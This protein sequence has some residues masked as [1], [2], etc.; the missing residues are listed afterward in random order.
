MQY[1]PFDEKQFYKITQAKIM[2]LSNALPAPS[3]SPAARPA[4]Y[5]IVLLVIMH[6]FITPGFVRSG[7]TREDFLKNKKTP[8]STQV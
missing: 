4:N 6:L 1:L 2:T 5:G 7:Q 3:I 8:I